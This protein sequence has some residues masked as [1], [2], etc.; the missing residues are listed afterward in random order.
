M[1]LVFI[2]L[3]STQAWIIGVAFLLAGTAYYAVQ[4][5]LRK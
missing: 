3:A 2:L 1:L 4:K 5:K